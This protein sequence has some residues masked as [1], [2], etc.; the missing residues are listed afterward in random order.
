MPMGLRERAQASHCPAEQKEAILNEKEKQEEKINAYIYNFSAISCLTSLLFVS[1]NNPCSPVSLKCSILYTFRNATDHWSCF[2]GFTWGIIEGWF[3]VFLALWRLTV[4][5]HTLDIKW[6]AWNLN[7]L[8]PPFRLCSHR[9]L[10]DASKH[11]RK[12]SCQQLGDYHKFCFCCFFMFWG[13]WG[14]F[15]S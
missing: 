1:V 7:P 12:Q 10:T 6:N 11:W 13:V 2:G 8:L 14:F 3:F 9:S 4:Y 15:F 5:N